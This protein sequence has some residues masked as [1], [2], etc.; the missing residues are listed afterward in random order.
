MID[1]GRWIS[2]GGCVVVCRNVTKTIKIDSLQK[3]F[4]GKRSPDWFLEIA[5]VSARRPVAGKKP[6][7]QKGEGLDCRSK[8]LR[9]ASQCF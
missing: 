5:D 4:E 8:R 9:F 6:F 3:I 1:S 7:G 2:K